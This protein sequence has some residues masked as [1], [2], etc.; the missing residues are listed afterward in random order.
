MTMYLEDQM[1]ITAAFVQC[2]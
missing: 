1:L 2:L